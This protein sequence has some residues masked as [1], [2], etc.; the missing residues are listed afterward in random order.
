LVVDDEEKVSKSLSGLLMDQGYEVVTVR[1]A[2]EC[3]Q[4]MSSQ[5][6][7][8]VILDIVMPEISGIK[9]L[10]KIKGEYKDTEVILIT[11]YADKEKAIATFRVGTYDFIEKPFESKEILNTVAHCLDQLDMKKKIERQSQELKESGERYRLLAENVVDVIW[12]MDIRSLKTTYVSPSVTRLRGYSVEEVMAQ[13]LEEILTPSSLDLAMKTL[14]EEMAIEGMEQKDPFRTRTLE[15]ECKCKD[16]STVWTEAKMTLL[17]R[18]DARPVEIL[19]VS[20]DITKRKQV[21]QALR[22]LSPREREIMQLVVEG[23]TSAEIAEILSISP[24]TVETYRSR[25]M[26]KL[27]VGNLPGLIKFA[28]QQRL[29]TP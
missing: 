27:G 5:H 24:K 18:V 14:E 19:G 17:R 15:L 4:T 21:E 13:T 10:Q 23:K 1:S 26:G 20:R 12:T 6:F 28:I 25:I 11:G 8:L 29:T 2:Q 9:V 3:L 22:R 16:G 7:D